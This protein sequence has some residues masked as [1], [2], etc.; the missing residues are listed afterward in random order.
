[1]CRSQMAKTK[2]SQMA[3]MVARPHAGGGKRM[4][5]TT[6]PSSF[7]IWAHGLTNT[8][9]FGLW[10]LDLAP[11]TCCR[12]CVNFCQNL[13]LRVFWSLQDLPPVGLHVLMTSRGR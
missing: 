12:C 8:D 1:M 4:P 2:G 13:M 3:V 7:I 10:H 6:S 11:S 9:I 5:R